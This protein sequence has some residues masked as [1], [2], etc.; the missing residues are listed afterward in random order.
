MDRQHQMLRPLRCPYSQWLKNLVSGKQL[1]STATT[2][3]PLPVPERSPRWVNIPGTPQ[4]SFRGYATRPGNSSTTDP[5]AA[6]RQEDRTASYLEHSYLNS[7]PSLSGLMVEPGLP[8]TQPLTDPA[9]RQSSVSGAVGLPEHTQSQRQPQITGQPGINLPAGTRQSN[10]YGVN[11]QSGQYD[12]NQGIGQ[13]DVNQ[14]SGQYDLNQGIGQYGLNQQSGQYDLNQVTG[15]YDVNQQSGQYDLNQGTG[16]Y[17]V[18]QQSGQYDLNQGTGQYDVNQQSGQYDLNQGIGQY[19]VNQQSGQYDLNQ[20][21]GQ[22]DVNQQSGEYDLN[23][24]T[25]QFDVDE[26]TGQYEVNRG[27]GQYGVNYG[28]TQPAL[29]RPSCDYGVNPHT[30]HPTLNQPTRQPGWAQGGTHPGMNGPTMTMQQR[31]EETIVNHLTRQS[32][33]NQAGMFYLPHLQHG[34]SQP[35]RMAQPTGQPSVGQPLS[36]QF[37]AESA[38]RAVWNLPT[39]QAGICQPARQT[40]MILPT[41]LA[42]GNQPESGRSLPTLLPGTSEL[43]SQSGPS[44][45]ARLPGMN[46]SASQAVTSGSTGHDG[47]PDPRTQSS[48]K[49]DQPTAVSD[50][51]TFL[52]SVTGTSSVQHDRPAAISDTSLQSLTGTSSVQHD[53]PAAISDTSLQSLR[54]PASDGLGDYVTSIGLSQGV[55]SSADQNSRSSHAPCVT[56]THSVERSGPTTTSKQLE[57]QQTVNAAS[58]D[59]LSTLLSQSLEQ[60][61]THQHT[62]T[63][64]RDSDFLSTPFSKSQEPVPDPPGRQEVADVDDIIFVASENLP[65]QAMKQESDA[66]EDAVIFMGSENLPIFSLPEQIMKEE[67]DV[68]EDDDILFQGVE[69]RPRVNGAVKKKEVT[70]VLLSRKEALDSEL[71]EMQEYSPAPETGPSSDATS[72]LNKVDS[73]HTVASEQQEPDTGVASSTDKQQSQPSAHVHPIASSPDKQQSQPSAKDGSVTLDNAEIDSDDDFIVL[74]DFS[75]DDEAIQEYASHTVSLSGQSCNRST[76]PARAKPMNALSTEAY[77]RCGGFDGRCSFHTLIPT[78]LELHLKEVHPR[79]EKYPCVHCGSQELGHDDL[80]QHLEGH[81]GLQSLALYCSHLDCDFSSFSPEEVIT[82]MGVCHADYHN[83]ICWR[84]CTKFGTLREFSAHVKRNLVTIIKCPHCSAKDVNR[85][86]VLS[87]IVTSH[88][89]HGRMVG[90]QKA[91]VCQERKLNNWSGQIESGG[92]DRDQ[93]PPVLERI[94]PL[95]SS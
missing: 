77:Y 48:V 17:D 90:I 82:H 94:E 79:D 29:N 71:E 92:A 26:G 14:Q 54:T 64:A 72:S 27:I 12:L 84:C 36:Q 2:G 91:L 83:H 62:V 11:Q 87:H 20:G 45:P 70:Y 32:G 35:L 85:K 23:Q 51:D 21:T 40:G 95:P 16:Q 49:H 3:A 75:D 28:N 78:Q 58:D 10:Q 38:R 19:D 33:I 1:S 56:E 31:N 46:Q 68:N 6:L 89:D 81:L 86:S 50:S 60:G 7:Y 93:G 43:I 34:M 42:G 69:R 44:Q 57:H 65:E 47:P 66:N 25:G 9:G 61:A 52:Q 18:N 74:E 53:R 80:L 88:P 55:A 67:T 73:A 37:M 63:G 30:W 76:Q 59:S 15:Q 8:V 24:G 41:R 39:S 13:Y 22:Y 5:Q 4:N